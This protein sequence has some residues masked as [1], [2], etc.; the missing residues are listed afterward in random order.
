MHIRFKVPR[1][2]SCNFPSFPLIDSLLRTVCSC[3]W[4]AANSNRVATLLRRQWHTH[5]R[6]LCLLC[7]GNW[8]PCLSV[9]NNANVVR[10]AR[11]Q[12]WFDCW[13]LCNK[14]E[15]VVLPRIDTL[16]YRVHLQTHTHTDSNT[17]ASSSLSLSVYTD[18]QGIQRWS[19]RPST[20]L[21]PQ[22][23]QQFCARMCATLPHDAAIC[24]I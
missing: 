19:R 9:A 20:E 7:Y 12:F 2:T 3:L 10:V 8:Q 16:A 4:T 23:P 11:L 17:Q 1:Y 6:L 18:G 22:L 21:L 24:C 15:F 5:S 14:T 13:S